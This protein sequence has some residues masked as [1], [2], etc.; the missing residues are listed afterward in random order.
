MSNTL[1]R[2]PESAL[3]P[4]S[5]ENVV[6]G[7]LEHASQILRRIYS[8]AGDAAAL[9]D[10]FH[11][12]LSVHM[13]AAERVL[14]PALTS[15]SEGDLLA[16]RLL[17]DFADLKS[18]LDDLERAQKGGRKF[19]SEKLEQPLAAYSHTLTQLALPLLAHTLTKDELLRLA[20]KFR[21]AEL[22]APTRN[23]RSFGSGSTQNIFDWIMA[24]LDMARDLSAGRSSRTFTD[25][26]G[27]L[28]PDVQEL[29]D[30]FASLS[31]KP[32]EFTEHN[33]AR[34]LP[35]FF[36]AQK[37]LARSRKLESPNA[38]VSVKDV[39]VH[40]SL[41]SVKA[42]LY[43]PLTST[44][45]PLIVFTPDGGWVLD[46]SEEGESIARALALMTNA[47]VLYPSMPLAPE[48][49][50]PKV[51]ELFAEVAISAA[52]ISSALTGNPRVGL[53]GDGAG[54]NLAA[55]AAMEMSAKGLGVSFLGLV[56][57]ITSTSTNWQ[58]FRD[59]ADAVPLNSAMVAWFLEKLLGAR[60]PD[61]RVDLFMNTQNVLNTLPS[62][63]II[64]ASRDPLRDQGEVF[65]EVLRSSGVQVGIV[66]YTGVPHS[67]FGAHAFLP[68]AS[69][70]LGRLAAAFKEAS[71]GERLSHPS[72][73]VVATL[74]K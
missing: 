42:K 58:S 21:T 25:A 45:A 62:T 66:R 18:S 5:L 60:A 41:G 14:H 68:K 73:E 15:I 54:G 38:T 28:D 55:W 6:A 48:S 33:Q 36:E 26:S 65:G 24:P 47:A 16:L 12:V 2:P 11:Y 51:H 64:T 49:P 39:A 56:C 1:L 69:D 17:S 67:F 40:T 59:A 23:H 63:F 61:R 29:V 43:Q 50:F 13:C 72:F 53:I 57:P 32:L 7:D 20:R 27:L 70:A 34:T 8:S 35:S 30:I 37:T 44:H 71:S 9:L 3:N 22:S 46:P 52:N 19:S 4:T 31:V 10:Q 74:K